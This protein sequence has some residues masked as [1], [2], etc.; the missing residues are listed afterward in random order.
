M[1]I[2]VT[3]NIIQ[4]FALSAKCEFEQFT[5]LN[6]NGRRRFLKAF[7]KNKNRAWHDVQTIF[8]APITEK[9]AIFE[10]T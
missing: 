7:N 1:Q 5:P 10:V 3:Y 4:D 9:I 8:Y 6:P 2:D